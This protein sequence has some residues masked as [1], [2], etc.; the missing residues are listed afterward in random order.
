MKKRTKILSLLSS[1]SLGASLFVNCPITHGYFEEA[2]KILN[3][4]EK[5][6]LKQSESLKSILKTDLNNIL[7]EINQKNEQIT[8][9]NLPG[10]NPMVQGITHVREFCAAVQAY[11]NSNDT[12]TRLD[13]DRLKKGLQAMKGFNM[14]LP[15]GLND[16]VFVNLVDPT[17]I[18]FSD[19][20]N[21]LQ[22]QTVKEKLETT[23]DLNILRKEIKK[24]IANNEEIKSALKLTV[25]SGNGN[26][27]EY[28]FTTD[29]WSWL[30]LGSESTMKDLA[31]AICDWNEKNPNSIKNWW[32]S[33]YEMTR[34]EIKKM[35]YDESDGKWMPEEKQVIDILFMCLDSYVK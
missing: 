25:N 34:N 8:G 5:L 28:E 19:L 10:G 26:E 12:D 17:V 2:L 9:L 1:F 20:Y 4:S 33:R 13:S 22:N 16:Q 23:K 29:G 18:Y 6:T 32:T 21:I 15:V 3:S 27:V 24:T 31:R 11:L 14:K 7:L 35:A 30:A